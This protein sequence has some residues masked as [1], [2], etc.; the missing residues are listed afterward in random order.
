MQMNS[1]SPTKHRVLA[2]FLSDV[3]TEVGRAV[4]TC[5]RFPHLKVVHQ[6]LN[7]GF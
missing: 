6:D 1:L 3:R 4:V 5:M 2:P 7:K